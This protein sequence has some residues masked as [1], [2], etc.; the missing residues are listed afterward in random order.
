MSLPL[1]AYGVFDCEFDYDS[2]EWSCSD[3]PKRSTNRNQVSCVD[4]ACRC[5]GAGQTG[6]ARDE[7]HDFAR[8]CFWSHRIL[9]P[10]G[11]G[12]S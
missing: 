9:L 12:L 3:D 6:A 4:L 11:S 10:L 5:G 7:G 2:Q 1:A 8:H